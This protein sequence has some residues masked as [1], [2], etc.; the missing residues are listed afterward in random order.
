[1]IQW[2]QVCSPE[3]RKIGQNFRVVSY[4]RELFDGLADPVLQVDW[5]EMTGPTFPPH[6]HAGFSAV[7]YLFQDSPNGF[8]NRDSIG[9]LCDIPP[10][11]V[12]WSRASRGLIHEETPVP[13]KG[14]VKGLQ[15]FMNLPESHQ[16]DPPA[17]FHVP[18]E[19]VK[20][21][22]GGGWFSR[23]GVQGCELAGDPQ[24]LPA[25]VLIEEVH[26]QH[27]ST[28]Q[29]NLPQGWGGLII[30]LN[31]SLGCGSTQL[32]AGDAVALVVSG[33]SGA[34]LLESVDKTRLALVVGERTNQPVYQKGSLMM[35]SEALLDERWASYQRGEYGEVP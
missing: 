14:P 6:P 34:V 35:A 33:G 30:V 28:R 31:G 10:G 24:A 25:P 7:T 15:I 27:G 22:S 17:A 11:A 32:N 16:L 26:M 9:N 29:L 12:H 21:L 5:F 2:S 3:P 23:I 19:S 8:I 1:M 4:S 13:G 18:V 20:Q